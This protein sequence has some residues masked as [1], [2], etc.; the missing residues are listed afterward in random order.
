MLVWR[1]RHAPRELTSMLNENGGI[2]QW[3]DGV[4]WR[5]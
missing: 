2:G 4:A 3:P 5:D 1:S